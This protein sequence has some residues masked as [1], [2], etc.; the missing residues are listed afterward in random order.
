MK[1]SQETD[2]IEFSPEKQSRLTDVATDIC[3]QILWRDGGK[4]P[5]VPWFSQDRQE[6]VFYKVS[7]MVIEK[8]LENLRLSYD[9][10]ARSGVYF[11]SLVLIS[12]NHRMFR[13]A[14]AAAKR[15]HPKFYEAGA[16]LQWYG[17]EVHPSLAFSAN[18]AL[19]TSMRHKGSFKSDHWTSRNIKEKNH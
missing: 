15:T 19:W 6:A 8:I 7:D 17:T 10:N 9:E 16:F 1:T 18:A 5:K 14:I 11:W 3:D 4:M 13:A 2:F 12:A